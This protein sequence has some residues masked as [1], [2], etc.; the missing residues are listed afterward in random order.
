MT[1]K[2][3]SVATY[4]V[5]F[6]ILMVLLVATVAAAF[7]QFGPFNLV[8][9][10]A[11]ATA[12][13]VLIGVYFMHLRFAMP[14]VRLVAVGALLGLCIGGVLTMSDSLTRGWYEPL[15][16]E[17]PVATEPRQVDRTEFTRDHDAPDRGHP[18]EKT[19]PRMEGEERP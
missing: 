2:P 9:A 17:N 13:A 5:V 15:D 19:A 11:I 10:L 12:K 18:A 14:L 3:I 7:F 8:V 16:F 1:H 4:T 6:A